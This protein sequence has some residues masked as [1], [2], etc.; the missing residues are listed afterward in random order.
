MMQGRSIEGGAFVVSLDFEL[1]WGIRD[2]APLAACRDRLLG[3]RRAVEVMLDLFANRGVHASWATVGMLFARGRDDLMVHLPPIESRPQYRN[4]Q[5]SPYSA[6]GELGRDERDDPF[7]FAASIVDRIA[8]TPG[9]ELA[10]HTFSHFY[11]LEPGATISAFEAD[12]AAARSIAASRGHTLRSLV[13]PRNQLNAEFLPALERAGISSYRENVRHWAYDARAVRGESVARRALRILDAYV[14]VTGKR[15]S[16]FSDLAGGA[17]PLRASAF[18]RPY[19]RHLSRLEPLR[20][21]RLR[22][23]M[24]TAALRGQMFHLWW[25]P[26]NFGRDLGANVKVLSALVDEFDGLR[27]S[28]GMQSMNMAEARAAGTTVRSGAA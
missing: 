23:E 27:R 1:H 25:H 28:H 3:A 2:H 4:G 8:E 22:D 9:Q 12:L 24:R 21:A 7:H 18:L 5:L 6:L 11:C 14:P 15:T 13:F 10:T 17:V 20:V 16:A 19:N 26:H